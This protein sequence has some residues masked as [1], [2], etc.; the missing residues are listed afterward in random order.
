MS[1]KKW[2]KKSLY[3]A[4]F[5]KDEYDDEDNKIS[6]YEKPEFIGLENIE[7]ISNAGFG[8]YGLSEM[9][10]GT[11]ADRIVR[12]L[13]DYDKYLDK[14]KENDLAYIRVD[15]DLINEEINGNQPY[16]TNANYRIDSVREQ[17]KKIAIYF[18]KLPNK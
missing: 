13:L 14:F 11:K 18:D 5:L 2:K 1:K 3:I 4:S 15:K 16:G 12:V 9:P 7:P 10:Y 6:T 17:N 8:G